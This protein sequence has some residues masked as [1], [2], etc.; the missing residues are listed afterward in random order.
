MTPAFKRFSLGISLTAVIVFTTFYVLK[1]T[2]PE[3]SSSFGFNS[4]HRADAGADTQTAL[5]NTNESLHVAETMAQEQNFD[6]ALAIL[7]NVNAEDQNNYDVKFLHARIL[8][9]SG[10]HDSAED[11]YASLQQDYPQDADIKVAFAYLKY[12][13]K[14]FLQAEQIFSQVLVNYPNYQDAK[15]GLERVRAAQVQ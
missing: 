11:K 12:Y 14:D 5:L 9:W 4:Q 8:A 6:Q 13:Q 10:D 7:K 15:T 2:K 1:T 3:M